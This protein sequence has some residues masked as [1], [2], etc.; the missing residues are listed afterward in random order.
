MEQNAMMVKTIL[1]GW[2]GTLKRADTLI[3]ELT[4]EQ[5]MKEVSPGRN[6]G[7]YLAGHLVAVHDAM[8]PLLGLGEAHYPML[9]EPFIKTPDN[10]GSYPYTIENIRNYWKEVNQDLNSKMAALT[11]NEWLEKHTAVS[12]EDFAKEPNRNRLNVLMS[13]TLHLSNHYGQMLFL[14]GTDE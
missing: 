13:R 5:L 12:A 3:N 6:R 10:K 9:A 11:P 14:K 4:D 2:T 1:D 7:I 8:L